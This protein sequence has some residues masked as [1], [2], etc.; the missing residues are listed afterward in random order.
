MCSFK[1]SIVSYR[2]INTNKSI[3]ICENKA[4]ILA[5]CNQDGITSFTCVTHLEQNTFHSMPLT[6]IEAILTVLSS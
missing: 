1:S 2:I 4:I 3:A 6:L 5:L